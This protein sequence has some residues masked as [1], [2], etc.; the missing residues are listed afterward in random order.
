M[1]T[2][3]LECQK[4]MD[5]ADH[6]VVWRIVYWDPHLRLPYLTECLAV[7]KVALGTAAIGVPPSRDP[8]SPAE[9]HAT[10]KRDYRQRKAGHSAR[11]TRD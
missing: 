5:G 6:S 1:L 11:R 10:Y 8:T 4:A 2:L 7:A 3:V 9:R